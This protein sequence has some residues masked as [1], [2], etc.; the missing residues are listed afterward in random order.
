[1]RSIIWRSKPRWLAALQALA[2]R[3]PVSLT[4]FENKPLREAVDN[5]LARHSID[6]IYVFSSQMA[7]YLPPRPRQRVIMDF[8]DV[9]S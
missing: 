6:T 3:R 8:V 5:I 2:L 9:D 1:N 7:Q 4:A